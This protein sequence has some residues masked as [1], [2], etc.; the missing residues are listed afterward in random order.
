MITQAHTLPLTQ[1]PQQ[2]GL[3]QSY[4][5]HLTRCMSL[6]VVRKQTRQQLQNGLGIEMDITE[7]INFQVEVQ[8]DYQ[9]SARSRMQSDG[10]NAGRLMCYALQN[11]TKIQ[12]LYGEI[13]STIG[14]G[15]YTFKGTFDAFS[16]SEGKAAVYLTRDALNSYIRIKNSSARILTDNPS[17]IRVI[18]NTFMLNRVWDQYGEDKDKFPLT[19]SNGR[20]I[21]IKSIKL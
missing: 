7:D 17:A 12:S 15:W 3:D 11:G 21:N 6:V 5:Q 8:F 1:M 14:D 20:T 13:P 10:L 4:Q 2:R 19:Y 16:A 9:Y 18:G